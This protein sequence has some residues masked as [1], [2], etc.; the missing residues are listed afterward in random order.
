MSAMLRVFNSEISLL[1]SK[2]IYGWP[3]YL[4]GTNIIS[5]VYKGSKLE[6]TLKPE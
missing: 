4:S 2:L 1:Q 3:N 5:G 6:T